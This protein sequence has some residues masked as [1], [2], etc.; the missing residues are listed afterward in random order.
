MKKTMLGHVALGFPPEGGQLKRNMVLGLLPL[1]C[2]PS[3][4]WLFGVGIARHG[5]RLALD[6]QGKTQNNI[7]SWPRADLALPHP[8]A[9]RP[10]IAWRLLSLL[11]GAV[12]APR[13]AWA[14]YTFC[15]IVLKIFFFKYN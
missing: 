13:R 4:R 6:L 5:P 10:S 12:Q 3:A 11:L 14:T 7:G 1:R 2:S 15:I 8:Q 9:G